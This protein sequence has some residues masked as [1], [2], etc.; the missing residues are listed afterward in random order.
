MGEIFDDEYRVPITDQPVIS[1]AEVESEI[2]SIVGRYSGEDLIA[3]LTA[4]C[5]ETVVEVVMTKY[6]SPRRI[7][8]LAD[9]DIALLRELPGN[10]KND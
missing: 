8:R 3:A 6:Q 1:S 5:L 10:I 4:H 7:E 9:D 2:R